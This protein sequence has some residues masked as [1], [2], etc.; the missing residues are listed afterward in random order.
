MMIPT[1]LPI[2]KVDM[3]IGQTR[4]SKSKR[5]DRGSD[6]AIVA[7]AGIFP[8]SESAAEGVIDFIVDIVVAV[9]TIGAPT[10]PDS[11]LLVVPSLLGAL[12]DPA[13]L[14]EKR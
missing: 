6:V 7:S 3:L 9:K 1:P 10:N 13:L 8:G 12:C 4:L 2:N 11:W 5:P 14:V